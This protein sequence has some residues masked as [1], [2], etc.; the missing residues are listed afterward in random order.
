MRREHDHRPGLRGFLEKMQVDPADVALDPRAIGPPHEPAIEQRLR[1]RAE[2][3]TGELATLALRHPRKTRA[4]IDARHATTLCGDGVQ[5]HAE[6][7]A[8][9]T[10]HRHRQRAE[11]TQH[12]QPELRHRVVRSSAR[13]IVSGDAGAERGVL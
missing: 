12:P 1:E 8:E 13:A 9:R 5:Q 7:R 3:R 4:Q 11:R 6:R 10:R 2:V